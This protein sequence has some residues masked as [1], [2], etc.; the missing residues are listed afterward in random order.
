M[1]PKKG[2][3]RKRVSSGNGW[4]KCEGTSS[5]NIGFP[6]ASSQ[7]LKRGFSAMFLRI[8]EL[9]VG[10]LFGFLLVCPPRKEPEAYWRGVAP[11]TRKTGRVCV[12]AA[13]G[14]GRGKTSDGLVGDVWFGACCQG[15]LGL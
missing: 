8:G 2:V 6:E 9:L 7:V 15:L 5:H 1:Q 13:G 12:T 4:M 10:L 3:P 11:G 14:P